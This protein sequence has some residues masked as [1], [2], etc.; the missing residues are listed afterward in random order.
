MTTP[1]KPGEGMMEADNGF[2]S[3]AEEFFANALAM[4]IC[5]HEGYPCPACLA[6]ART[7]M[8]CEETPS[9]KGKSNDGR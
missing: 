8:K 5:T 3:D 2:F 4:S 6:E 7:A 9:Q 1:V